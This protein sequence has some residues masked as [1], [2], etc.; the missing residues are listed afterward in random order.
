MHLIFKCTSDGYQFI[1]NIYIKKP[2]WNILTVSCKRWT[3]GYR[4]DEKPKDAE[5]NGF[6]TITQEP[7]S[8]GYKFIDSILKKLSMCKPFIYSKIGEGLFQKVFGI[9]LVRPRQ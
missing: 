2:F 6:C 7:I 4:Y 1:N 8:K 3:W 9:I 5:T